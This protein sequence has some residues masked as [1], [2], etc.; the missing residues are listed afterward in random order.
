MKSR[1]HPKAQ[2]SQFCLL[3]LDGGNGAFKNLP[4]EGVFAVYDDLP[5]PGVV[6]LCVA[7][8]LEELQKCLGQIQNKG[9]LPDP[10]RVWVET[11]TSESA[12]TAF[13]YEGLVQAVLAGIEQ[14]KR[15]GDKATLRR[16]RASLE[17]K[18]GKPGPKVNPENNAWLI[19]LLKHLAAG[20]ALKEAALP[21]PWKPASASAKLSQL[22]WRFYQLCTLL[23][24]PLAEGWQSK[25]AADIIRDRFG[26][27]FPNDVDAAQ[28]AYRRGEA[29]L[30]PEERE[31]EPFSVRYNLRQ[32]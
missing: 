31:Y 21:K 27:Q 5:G 3:D 9:M 22:C 4:S 15:L 20:K 16:V 2:R 23:G 6:R 19:E 8:G 13:D 28:E 11:A 29:Q 12:L 10:P 1:K 17:S 30:S 24:T 26:F 7:R 32:L 25:H 18:G 14:I